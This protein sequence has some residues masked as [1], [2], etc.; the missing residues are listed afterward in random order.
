MYEQEEQE[1]VI[2]LHHDTGKRN[3]WKTLEAGRIILYSFTL[4]GAINAA[5]RRT[6][7]AI[8]NPR[9]QSLRQAQQEMDQI[10]G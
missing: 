6:Q 4:E 7:K 1:L 10:F 9:Q 2:R 8:E 3:F 5:E